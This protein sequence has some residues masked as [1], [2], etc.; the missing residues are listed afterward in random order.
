[1]VGGLAVFGIANILG[2][3]SATASAARLRPPRP[4]TGASRTARRS[5]LLITIAEIAGID[6][7][8]LLDRRATVSAG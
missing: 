5:A 6:A 2:S 8:R 1:M 3:W 4:N 7:F